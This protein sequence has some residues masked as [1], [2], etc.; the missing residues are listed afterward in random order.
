MSASPEFVLFGRSHVLSLV[1]IASISIWLLPI[2][3]RIVRA[4]WS[5]PVARMLALLIIIEL[6]VKTMG[7]AAYGAPWNKL[8]PLQICDVN[9]VLC[10]LML[11]KRSYG[12]YQ[13]AYF[14]AMAASI[15]AMLTPDLRYDFPHPIF[16]FFFAGH[17]L[18]VLGVLYATW[19][20]GF[21]PRF[22]SLGIALVVTASYAGFMMV[23]N[24]LLGMNYLYLRAKPSAPSVLDYM[25]PWPWYLLGLVL[26][27]VFACLL[28]YAPFPMARVIRTMK[29][30]YSTG[31]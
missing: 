4:G 13:V 27:C 22:R 15:A 16:V 3:R 18:S 11:V 20:F 12:M 26:L 2:S 10:A 7:H 19:V 28:A 23:M 24:F 17:G 25:G 8:L 29:A 31:K 1:I 30:K 5:T 9:A 14:W 6:T 21:Q